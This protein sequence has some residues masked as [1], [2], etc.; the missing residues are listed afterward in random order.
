MEPSRRDKWLMK[1]RERRTNRIISER[2]IPR[3]MFD[4]G[5][6]IPILAF[7]AF[8]LCLG[9]PATARAGSDL[10][11]Y[12][13]KGF[14]AVLGEAGPTYEEMNAIAHAIRNR[15]T[16]SGVY[17]LR[18]IAWYADRESLYRMTWRGN[19]T[20]TDQ[21]QTRAL[22]AWFDSKGG[23]DPVRGAGHWLSDWDLKNAKPALTAWRFSMIETAYIGSTHFYKEQR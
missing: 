2:G 20:I 17:G 22:K 13:D 23:K 1:L 6:E 10:T 15:G 9:L 19:Q 12:D 14:R 8:A 5:L 4:G 16:F 11:A 18:R 7:I 3:W 21:E